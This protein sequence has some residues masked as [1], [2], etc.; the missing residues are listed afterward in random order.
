VRKKMEESKAVS[1]KRYMADLLPLL[2]RKTLISGD[3]R[4]REKDEQ[5]GVGDVDAFC[6]LV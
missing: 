2:Q 1:R 5:F 4:G 6:V 3:E